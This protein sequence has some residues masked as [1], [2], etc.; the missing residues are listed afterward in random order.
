VEIE[1]GIGFAA[2]KIW[3]TLNGK[4]PMAKSAIAKATGLGADLLDQGI[5]WLAREGKLV[6]VKAGK[7]EQLK[8]KG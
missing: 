5:G 8:L 7:V 1:T 3:Q 2:G 6:V 4:G